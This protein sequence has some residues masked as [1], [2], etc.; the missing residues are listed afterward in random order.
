MLIQEIIRHYETKF[1]GYL[2]F[3][4]GNEFSEYLSPNRENIVLVKNAEKLKQNFI[5]FLTSLYNTNDINLYHQRDFENLPKYLSTGEKA[6]LIDENVVD[7]GDDDKSYPWILA[8]ICEY[9]DYSFSSR[10]LIFARKNLSFRFESEE[11][12]AGYY[13]LGDERG[14]KD[15]SEVHMDDPYELFKFIATS[16]SGGLLKIVES[17]I[18]QAYG[19]APKLVEDNTTFL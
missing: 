16:K 19:K 12:E 15:T 14:L 4:K 3:L 1:D 18:K 5:N 9:Q 8:D 17:S 11:V 7:I 13:P 6:L 2:E 10:E